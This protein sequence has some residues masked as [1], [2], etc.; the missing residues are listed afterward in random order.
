MI[1]AAVL[2]VGSILFALLV[3]DRGAVLSEE[4]QTNRAKLN[5]LARDQQLPALDVPNLSEQVAARYSGLAERS[6]PNWAYYRRPAI[7]TLETPVAATIP[8]HVAGAIKRLSVERLKVHGKPGILVTGMAPTV[9]NAKL[10]TVSLEVSIEGQDEWRPVAELKGA[11]LETLVI[12]GLESGKR[13][14]FRVKSRATALG[15]SAFVAPHQAEQTSKPVDSILVPFDLSFTA[16]GPA[17]KKPNPAGNAIDPGTVR[18]EKEFYDYDKGKIEKIR[19]AK[20][21]KEVLPGTKPAAENMVDDNYYVKSVEPVEKRIRI[22]LKSIDGSKP[23]L[24]IWDKDPPRPTSSPPVEVTDV[25]AS[26]TPPSE[27]TEAKPKE[28]AP[29]ANPKPNPFGDPKG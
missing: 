10:D 27:P 9:K 19:A 2:V 6:P 1:V 16:F 8:E 15:S 22:Q 21:I 24:E 26:E 7:A 28:T 13:Y 25:V 17:L 11:E 12:D 4:I 29:P 5:D 20:A 14:V 3:E 18:I 23:D